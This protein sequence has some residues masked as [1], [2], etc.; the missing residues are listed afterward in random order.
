M[1]DIIL[2]LRFLLF[3]LSKES[4]NIGFLSHLFP[5]RTFLMSRKSAR[6]NHLENLFIPSKN[7]TQ[8]ITSVLA[9]TSFLLFPIEIGMKT[10][11]PKA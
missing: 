8:E 7:T 3:L 1:H 4:A 10:P 9:P 2:L 6:Q 11:K 5:K